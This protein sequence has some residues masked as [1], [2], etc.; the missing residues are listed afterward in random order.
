MTHRTRRVVALSALTLIACSGRITSTA[1]AEGAEAQN[2]CSRAAPAA[3]GRQGRMS[4]KPSKEDLRK[5]LTPEQFHV[6]QECGTEPA[7]RNAYWNNHA[8]G[9]YVDVVSGEPLFSSRDKF[10]SG[11]GWPSFTRPVEATNV[12]T[13]D[14]SS[15][16][17][18][19]TEVRS[20]A[21]ASHLGHVFPDGPGPTGLRYCINSASLRF[22]PADKLAEQG[23]AKYAALF[24]EVKQSQSSAP[25]P[26]QKVAADRETAILAGGCF[27]GMEE[28][29]RKIPGVIETE[30]GYTGGTLD[31]PDYEHVKTGRTGHAES[32]KVVFDPK[33]LSYDALL[34]WFFRM[35]DPT[36]ANRQGNDVGTQYRSAIFYTSE[37]Q[38]R[39]AER[40][41]AE[42]DKAGKWK[43]PIVTQIVPAS[44]FYPAEGYHQDYLVKNPGG[45]TCHFLRD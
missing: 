11:T 2:E 10:D 5:Q 6:T 39:T 17:M 40:V 35:H 42:T 27:W 34:A 31:D 19:R 3:Q 37:E 13:E 28:I 43:K 36:T 32:I 29:V 4:E 45:Y 41:K 15:H 18:V 23:Y 1:A 21:G 16:G 26:A 9:L 20:K 12:E 7:F 38:K 44:K 22:I 30:V 14:D 25:G 8:A 24:P 33:K